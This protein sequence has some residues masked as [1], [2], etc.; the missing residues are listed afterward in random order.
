[1]SI[2]LTSP[3]TGSAQTGFTTPGYT[4]VV[5]N[6]PNNRSK[7][8]AITAINGTQSGVRA[9]SVG[10][11]FTIDFSLPG[12]IKTL[13]AVNPITGALR[14]PVPRN[15]HKILVTKGVMVLANQP[16]DKSYVDISINLAAGSELADLP[17]NKAMLSLAIGALQQ[18]SAGLGDTV[19]NGL[20]D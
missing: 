17:N 15:K 2:N 18:F 3:V 20:K 4:V 6:A 12:Q 11:P 7:Q 19:G 5:G 8:W 10:D 14:Y 9:H 13:P 1:M 16:L